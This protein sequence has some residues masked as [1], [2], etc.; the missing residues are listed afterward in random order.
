MQVREA[1]RATKEEIAAL[2]ITELHKEVSDAVKQL[3]PVDLSEPALSLQVERRN[4][5]NLPKVSDGAMQSRPDSQYEVHSGKI[6]HAGCRLL[7]PLRSDCILRARR[8]LRG[9]ACEPFRTL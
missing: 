2:P 4:L 9:T 5:R 7:A 8:P 1:E 6:V 3:F